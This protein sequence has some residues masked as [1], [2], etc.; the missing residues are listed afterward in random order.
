MWTASMWTTTVWG[1]LVLAIGCF[2]AA[3]VLR[4]VGRRQRQI[5]LS[6]VALG[7]LLIIGAGLDL[8]FAYHDQANPTTKAV[9][10]SNPD[11]ALLALG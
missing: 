6:L 2:F 11:R 5:R 8:K 10:G 1:L 7:C 3:A 4:S 9:G